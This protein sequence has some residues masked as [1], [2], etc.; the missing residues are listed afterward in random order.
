MSISVLP[1]QPIKLLDSAEKSRLPVSVY[2]AE[3]G[4]KRVVSRYEDDVWDFWPYITRENICDFEKRIT[5]QVKLP[6]GSR[7]T[8][9]QHKQLLE[10]AKD[11]IWS[12]YAEPLAGRKRP[13][14]V[15]LCYKQKLLRSLLRWLVDQGITRFSHLE[16]RALDYV[17]V[18]ARRSSGTGTVSKGQHSRYL[19]IVEDLYDQREKL[20]DALLTHPWPHE[21]STSLAGLSSKGGVKPKT[22]LIPESVI[23]PLAKNALDYVEN[24]ADTILI[25]RDSRNKAIADAAERGFGSH[26][27]WKRGAESAITNGFDG[28]LH[29]KEELIRLRTACYIV[30]D[31]FCGARSSEILSLGNSC[32]AHTEGHDGSYELIWLHGTKYKMGEK[33]HRWLVPPIV[34]TAVKVM[35]RYAAPLQEE[36]RAEEEKLIVQAMVAKGKERTIIEQRL[37][38]VRLQKS[39]LFLGVDSKKDNNISVITSIAINNLLKAF[40]S[41]HGILGNDGMPYS[42]YSHQFRRT[43]A[44]FIGK[45]ELGD[46]RYLQEHYGHKSFDMTVYYAYDGTDEY[47]LDHDLLDVI[48]DSK[49]VRQSEILTSLV[50]SDTPLANGGHWLSSWRNT[51]LTAKNKKELFRELSDSI[52]LNGT[53][54]SWCVGSAK[55]TGCGGLC[56][57]EAD[58]CTECSHGIIG[59]EHLPVWKGIVE[60]QE[61]VMAMQDLGRPA[62]A[63]AE[64]ILAKARNVIEKLEGA[65]QCPL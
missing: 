18:A 20:N 62:K 12:L 7:L 51:V 21:T 56:I 57:F 30:I 58:M 49:K 64:R 36:L 15:T 54:H 52:V 61:E 9:P 43:F 65:D 5:W 60:Q 34:E 1:N 31:M 59:S 8:D 4:V 53:G 32:I 48:N 47:E 37:S 40:C 17:P 16:G 29:L 24:R 38:K 55:G 2:L 11:F 14:M 33:P 46:L 39:K 41:D 10:S 26:S 23:K 3:D 45:S 35:E 50:D 63:R 6:G 13:S 44:W 28:A 19:A 25:A 22:K 42:L 27:L